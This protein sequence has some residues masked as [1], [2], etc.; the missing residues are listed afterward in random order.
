MSPG[1]ADMPFEMIQRQLPVNVSYAFTINKAQGQTLPDAGLYLP[2][3]PFSHG[4]L[5]VA[6]SRRRKS[7]MPVSASLNPSD[8]VSSTFD[9]ENIV[10]PEALTS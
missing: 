7:G 10:Y 4:Q 6:L 9:T 3:A 5:Y 1:E 8:P 2:N